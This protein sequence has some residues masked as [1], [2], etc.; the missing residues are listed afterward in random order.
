[1]GACLSSKDT[2]SVT[3]NTEKKMTWVTHNRG[4]KFSWESS[5]GIV[6][7]SNCDTNNALQSVLQVLVRIKPCMNFFMLEQMHGRYGKL[8][9]NMM[10]RA[11]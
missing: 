9:N 7:M 2:I 6:N 4:V 1:M 5:N 3:S 11:Y 10:E 8:M